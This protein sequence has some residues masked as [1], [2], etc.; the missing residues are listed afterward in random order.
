[1]KKKTLKE[2]YNLELKKSSVIQEMSI[3]DK[4]IRLVDRLR[5]ETDTSHREILED[6]LEIMSEDEFSKFAKELRKLYGYL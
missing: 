5:Q 6:I 4:R 2:T 3:K 1:M